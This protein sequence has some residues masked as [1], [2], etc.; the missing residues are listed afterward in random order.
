MVRGVQQHVI[1]HLNKYLDG[2]FFKRLIRSEFKDNVN[3]WDTAYRITTEKILYKELRQ[4]GDLAWWE[5]S[6]P[7]WNTRN[8]WDTMFS[9]VNKLIREDENCLRAICYIF[10]MENLEGKHHNVKNYVEQGK[11]YLSHFK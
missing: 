6:N 10:V 7:G 11:K 2:I 4:W 8:T 5:Y 3:A 9:V 1:S